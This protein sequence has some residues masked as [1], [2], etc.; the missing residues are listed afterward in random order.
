VMGQA[1][2]LAGKLRHAGPSFWAKGRGEE[3]KDL[4]ISTRTETLFVQQS[5]LCFF[6]P[7]SLNCQLWLPL[8]WGSHGILL[9]IA[10]NNAGA[11][12]RW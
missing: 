8:R 9:N 2:D 11:A 1:S 7:S 6:T 3:H 10:R 5:G 4:H 12:G